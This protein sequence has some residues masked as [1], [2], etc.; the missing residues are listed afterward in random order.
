[1]NKAVRAM[2]YLLSMVLLKKKSGESIECSFGGA[3]KQIAVQDST[4]GKNW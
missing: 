2:K 1:M 4:A 3:S